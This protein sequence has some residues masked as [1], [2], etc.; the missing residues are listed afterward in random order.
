MRLQ[1]VPRAPPLSRFGE[2]SRGF[3]TKTAWHEDLD[4]RMELEPSTVE[5]QIANAVFRAKTL[6]QIA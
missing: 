5:G 6:V 1:R 3:G 4:E 2:S